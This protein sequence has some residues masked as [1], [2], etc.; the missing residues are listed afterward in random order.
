VVIQRKIREQYAALFAVM[1]DPT[2]LTY[3][4]VD[5]PTLWPDY[6]RPGHTVL[7]GETAQIGGLTWGFV[8]GGLQT[9]MRTPY[10]ISDEAYAAK[11]AALGPVDVLACHIPPDVPEL[12]YDV[13]ARRFE[14]GS[15]ATLDLIR[16]TQPGLVLFGHVHQPLQARI[17]IG[18]TECVNVGHLRGTGSPYV[19]AL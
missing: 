7:D 17:R 9:P 11:V 13:Q 18:K 12:L 1:P 19:L 2:Y 5:V 4:N 3:G 6:L 15:T 8:G 10:E 14:R 16:D